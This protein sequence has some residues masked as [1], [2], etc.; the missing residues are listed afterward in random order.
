M[1]LICWCPLITKVLLKPNFVGDQFRIIINKC[2]FFCL[3]QNEHVPSSLNKTPTSTVSVAWGYC[4]LGCLKENPAQSIIL[5]CDP[6]SSPHKILFLKTD[7]K[8]VMTFSTFS[9]LK[10]VST[11][12]TY[13]TSNNYQEYFFA[14][15]SFYLNYNRTLL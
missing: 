5:T 10:Q 7:Q 3:F 4:S 14:Q 2:F 6:S 11:L 1:G 15:I 12:F 13:E 8:F 9:L